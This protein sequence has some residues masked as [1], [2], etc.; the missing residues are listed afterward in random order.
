MIADT[1][2][3]LDSALRAVL[4]IPLGGG[5]VQ[6]LP[7]AWAGTLIDATHEATGWAVLVAG[8]RGIL[9]IDH[10]AASGSLETVESVPPEVGRMTRGAPAVPAWRISPA[11]PGVS[12]IHI[13]PLLVFTRLQPGTQPAISR[14]R[15]A[16]DDSGH[17]YNLLRPKW[18]ASP[19]LSLGSATLISLADVGSDLRLLIRCDSLGHVVRVTALDVA[20]GLLTSEPEAHE[21]AML[22]ETDRTDVV[23]YRYAWGNPV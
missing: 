4:R 5:Q 2:A 15:S 12:V 16:S 20:L 22:R 11:H 1:V 3:V 13:R 6:S 19:V 21:L 10:L 18:M 17:E 23:V 8:D 9:K 14:F 7:A